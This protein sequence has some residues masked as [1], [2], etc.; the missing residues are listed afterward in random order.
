VGRLTVFFGVYGLACT[1][2]LVATTGGSV[3]PLLAIPVVALAAAAVAPR[4]AASAMCAWCCL[5]FLGLFMAPC[6]AGLIAAARSAS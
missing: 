6:A 3:S 4:L 1:A 2:V 5:S